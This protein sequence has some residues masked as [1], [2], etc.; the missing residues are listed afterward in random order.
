MVQNSKKKFSLIL[1][2]LSLVIGLLAACSGNTSGTDSNASGGKSDDRYGGVLTLAIDGEPVG[3]GWMPNIRRPSELIVASTALE[4]LGRYDEEG[5]QQAWLAESWEADPNVKTLTIHL[6]KGIKFHDDTDFNAE[7]VKWNIEQFRVTKKPVL[8]ENDTE[9]VEVIDDQTVKLTM[10]EWNLD[11][12]DR[13]LSLRITSPAVFEKNGQD[14]ANSNPV[15]TGPFKLKEYQKGIQIEFEKFDGYWQE[16]KPYLDGVV[17]KI[18]PEAMTAEASVKNGDINGIFDA[19]F[20]VAK[21]LS[22][23][24]DVLEM[25]T[26]LGAAGSGLML[27][28]ADPKSPFANKKVREALSYA[29]DVESLIDTLTFGYAI[30]TDQFVVPTAYS[31]NPNLSKKSYDPGK[32]KKLLAEAGYPD[33]FKTTMDFSNSPESQLLYTAVQGYLKEVG[34]DLELSPNDNAKNQ[35]LV[36]SKWNGII[37]WG[38]K[39]QSNFYSG[40]NSNFGVPGQLYAKGV[41]HP[42]DVLDKLS[43][44]QKAQDFETQKQL[45]LELQQLIFE[46]HALAIPFYINTMPLVVDKNVQDSGFNKTEATFW[47]PEAAWLKK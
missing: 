41:T 3:L 44:V 7:A 47:E 21:N 19:P 20:E 10:K 40:A 36:L 2:C 33:G 1:L 9:S 4:S 11:I 22:K 38:F 6:K 26:G 5:I 27:N 23:E 30:K 28:S 25:E 14:W 42:Q 39:S 34:I 8:N 16:G 17:W 35:E 12:I 45:Y 31:Y 32:A 18:M 37:N 46:E 15:G 43:E 13:V 29:I 24:F